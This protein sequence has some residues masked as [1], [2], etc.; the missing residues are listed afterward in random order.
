MANV[1]LGSSN[2]KEVYD[3]INSGSNIDTS[4]LAK[5][6]EANTF[7]DLNTFTTLPQSEATPTDNKDLATKKY[8]D[9][10]ANNKVSKTGPET[11][12]GLY[13]HRDQLMVVN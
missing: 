4:N 13:A 12:E 10:T 9:D 5:L 2:L 6:N 11:I 7:T 1:E 3:A 8:V